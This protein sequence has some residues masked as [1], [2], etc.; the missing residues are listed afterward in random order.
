MISKHLIAISLCSSFRPVLAHFT[1]TCMIFEVCTCW[2]SM[3]SSAKRESLNHISLSC[4]FEKNSRTPRTK[5]QTQ[6][7]IGFTHVTK[8]FDHILRTQCCCLCHLNSSDLFRFGY[9]ERRG[10][11]SCRRL[12]SRLMNS[13][14]DETHV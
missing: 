11:Q 5:I 9:L 13:R 6:K 7:L 1:K 14:C 12:T 4:Y 8:K 3:C 10:R 2:C